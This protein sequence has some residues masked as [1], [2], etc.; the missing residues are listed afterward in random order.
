VDLHL[1]VDQLERQFPFP[2]QALVVAPQRFD[3]LS[4]HPL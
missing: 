3:I 4:R 1:W 2:V